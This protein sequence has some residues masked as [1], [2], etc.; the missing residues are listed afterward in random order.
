MP[1]HDSVAIFWDYENC[2]PQTGGSGFGV[3]HRLRNIA[4]KYG[5]IKSFKAYLPPL[6]DQASDKSKT[7][8]AELQSS[9]VS[10]IDCQ[11]NGRKDVADKMMLVD[12][13]QFGWDNAAPATIVLVTADRDFAYG[14]SVLKMRH[15][16]VILVAP[17]SGAVHE[18]LKCQ[19]SA[20][21]DWDTE[22][23]GKPV[24]GSYPPEL[25]AVHETLKCQAS[26]IYDW[27]TEVLGKPVSGSY[28]PELGS[29]PVPQ[30]TI[31]TRGSHARRQSDASRLPTIPQ[32]ATPVTASNSGD[33]RNGGSA[34]HS[35]NTSDDHSSEPGQGSSSGHRTLRQYASSDPVL[36]SQWATKKG[37]ELAV[38]SKGSS[39]TSPAGTYTTAL[40][41]SDSTSPTAREA[42]SPRIMEHDECPYTDEPSETPADYLDA[43]PRHRGAPIDSSSRQ[44]QNV[45]ATLPAPASPRA[46]GS[47]L[48]RP[49][50]AAA[51]MSS[52]RDPPP[53]YLNDPPSAIVEISVQNMPRSHVTATYESVPHLPTEPHVARVNLHRP[54][55]QAFFPLVQLLREM[56]D[57]GN[58]RPLRSNVAI[59][60]IHRQK[61]VYE[62]ARVNKFK[63][64]CEQACRE[65]IVELGGREGGAW[66]SLSIP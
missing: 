36:E 45:T 49:A 35:R 22:V 66:I 53:D 58:P 34:P 13:M 32:A 15:Y 20:I 4:L 8:R 43:N 62:L 23:L 17:T 50:T 33:S 54:I 14:V 37:K 42:H 63:A 21:Y 27:D 24:S 56:R 6:A 51:I 9:G 60:L 64:Y 47:P 38:G 5:S 59:K 57:E 16:R 1:L 61:N 44:N 55:P 11:N 31:A 26:A 19:A 39:L 41:P 46:V 28:P 40:S 52:R 7:L 65:G 48:A 25:G 30:L 12:M 18:T 29:R 3:A 10:L 2:A